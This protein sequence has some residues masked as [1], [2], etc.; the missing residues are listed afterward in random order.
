MNSSVYILYSPSL[1]S[2]YT[3]FT[4]TS[5]NERLNK[6][7]EKFYNK[8]Y[9]A[10]ASDWEIYL[11]IECVSEKQARGIEDHIKRMKSK[12]YILNLKRYPNII[13]E[14]LSKYTDQ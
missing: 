7:N 3:G 4:T 8:K 9:T 1:D 12:T 11:S 10:K 2:F 6:H 14:L 13:I 5:V